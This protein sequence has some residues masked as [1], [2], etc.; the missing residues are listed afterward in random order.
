MYIQNNQLEH[1]Q[2]ISLRDWQ[3]RFIETEKYLNYTITD[4]NGVK[5]LWK[6]DE[7]TGELKF[8]MVIDSAE[9]SGIY[10]KNP[11]TYKLKPLAFE[12]YD[13]NLIPM[14]YSLDQVGW[15]DTK[16]IFGQVTRIGEVQ[17]VRRNSIFVSWFKR[18][19]DS[20][21]VGVVS[22]IVVGVIMLIIGII[23]VMN[24][25]KFS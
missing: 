7:E 6:V 23:L 19:W 24:N 20:L 14:T 2:P 21:S 9:G 13:K 17:K 4:Y 1:P 16:I 18:N 22:G 15:D 5:E 8:N 25:I 12:H 3:R 10:Q 11:H